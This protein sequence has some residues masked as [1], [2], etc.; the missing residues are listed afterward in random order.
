M[1]AATIVEA[2]DVLPNTNCMQA[3]ER[4]EKAFFVP[5]DLDL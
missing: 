3:A 5:G 2:K 1:T 4:A